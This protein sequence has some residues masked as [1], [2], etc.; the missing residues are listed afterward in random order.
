MHKDTPPDQTLLQNNSGSTLIAVII[1]AVV[2]GIILQAIG[3]STKN[4]LKS[5]GRQLSKVASLNIAEA[6]KESFYSELRAETFIPQPNSDSLVFS[7][8]PFAGGTY[9]LR[10]RTDA[11]PELLTITSFG[12][13]RGETTKVEL[14]TRF[15]PEISGWGFSQGVGG[16]IVSRYSVNIGGN[17]VVDGRDYDSLNSLTGKNAYGIWTCMEF[18][19]Q[20][21]DALV[22]GG[23][24]APLNRVA[25]PP[26]FDK[27]VQK[28]GPVSASLSS[29]EAFFGV[30]NG[31]LDKFKVATLSTPFHGVVYIEGDVGPVD[32]KNSSGILIVHNASKTAT[33]K[34]T[35]GTFKGLMICDRVDKINGEMNILGAVVALSDFNAS[36]FGNGQATIHYSSQILD[37]LRGIC[38]NLEMVLEERSWKELVL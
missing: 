13:I 9:S 11:N 35:L 4:T 5:S 26:V 36:W 32:F 7:E 31:A 10:C 14:H 28:N 29:P 25:I 17:I 6:A 19:Q 16:A 30:E 27:V 20:G 1:L 23:G 22:G 2:A 21:D 24:I 38:D 34:G 8:I 15:G 37:N 12:A 18:L 3:F 33:F